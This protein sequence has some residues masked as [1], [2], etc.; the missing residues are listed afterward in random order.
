MAVK[1]LR[2]INLFFN[3]D[4]DAHKLERLD[5]FCRGMKDGSVTGT[6]SK[7]I[8]LTIDDGS[9]VDKIPAHDLDYSER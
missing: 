8:K 4:S 7:E 2:K 9:E 3:G 1:S 5:P 6:L